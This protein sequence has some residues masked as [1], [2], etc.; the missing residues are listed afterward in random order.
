MENPEQN[1][2][3]LKDIE[4]KLKEKDA[5]EESN[6]AFKFSPEFY[7]N[8]S[9][10][11]RSFGYPDG[12]PRDGL[13]ISSTIERRRGDTKQNVRWVWGFADSVHGLTLLEL[14][15]LHKEAKEKMPEALSLIEDKINYFEGEGK[16][17]YEKEEKAKE[18]IRSLDL[19]LENKLIEKEHIGEDVYR[20][21]MA[22]AKE[23]F[24]YN[25]KNLDYVRNNKG[26]LTNPQF[27]G[28][29][30]DNGIKFL[31]KRTHHGSIYT[32]SIPAEWQE[33]VEEAMKLFLE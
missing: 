16:E 24:G 8:E 2:N 13:I 14:K 17:Q 29:E 6:E 7:E 23:L 18:I 28:K 3:N 20:L 25:T 5:H 26:D 15:E 33:K 11:S 21:L 9:G 27:Y 19:P 4:N 30:Y 32:V 22:K 10:K 12:D 1:L 31:E